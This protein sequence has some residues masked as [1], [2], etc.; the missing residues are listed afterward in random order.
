MFELDRIAY[1]AISTYL[2]GFPGTLNIPTHFNS[3]HHIIHIIHGAII[4][5]SIYIYMTC[6]SHTL[7][8]NNTPVE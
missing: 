7:L 2:A 1:Y 5:M 3:Q 6:L 4:I 8:V